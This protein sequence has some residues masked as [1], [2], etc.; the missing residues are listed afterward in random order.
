MKRLNKARGGNFSRSC[1]RT[2]ESFNHIHNQNVFR[3]C[4]WNQPPLTQLCMYICIIWLAQCCVL[5]S[6][7][8]CKYNLELNIHN[9]TVRISEIDV[10]LFCVSLWI[11]ADTVKGGC[12]K[13]NN[14]THFHK[15]K[16]FYFW[17]GFLIGSW[18]FQH[19]SSLAYISAFP[20]PLSLS[21][22]VYFCVC[23][24]YRG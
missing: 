1:S 7:Y 14:L 23:N 24:N 4:L 2:L 5:F 11:N 9:S 20:L 13:V 10:F 19:P 3:V 17:K 12:W 15:H 18:S 22:C 21:L 16:K 6:L 8:T